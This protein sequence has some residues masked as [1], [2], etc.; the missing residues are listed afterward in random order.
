MIKYN[1]AKL[2][3][4]A[5]GRTSGY[6]VLHTADYSLVAE[7]Q[8]RK[9][10]MRMLR[11][12]AAEVRASIVA[13]VAADRRLTK[14][15]TSWENLFQDAPDESW[16]QRLQALSDE[17]AAVAARTVGN[18]LE[19]DGKARDK[20]FMKEAKKA[21]GIDLDAVIRS[22]DL[23]D[24][25]TLATQRSAGLIKNIGQETVN[26][27]SQTVYQHEIQGLPIAELQKKLR[28]DFGMSAKRA[29]LVAR[30]QIN[31]F[32][33]D[34]DKLRQQQAGVDEYEWQTSQGER[35]RPRHVRCNHKIYKWGQPTDAE[36][37]LPPG[38]PIQCRCVA[39]GII[40]FSSAEANEA[41]QSSRSEQA[42]RIR[43]AEET[44]KRR[45][46]ERAARKAAEAA[47]RP[48][49]RSSR[50]SAG[51]IPPMIIPPGD[52]F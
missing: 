12:I 21:L 34:V 20:K 8:F 35:V 39:N 23:F 10:I 44:L 24:A 52:R 49:R 25:V 22:E 51:D 29:K 11:G 31:K 40:R 15:R 37:G 33:S 7:L 41:V 28:E 19:L 30:D 38:Q 43:A 9:A 42:E 27:I 14:S 18:I 1:L 4:E 46:E 50:P 48:R 6:A 3:R 16:F 32:G 45:A 17:L 13:A 2:G 36:G 5:T 47:A 26:R